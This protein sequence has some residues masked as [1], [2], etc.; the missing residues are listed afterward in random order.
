MVSIIVDSRESKSKIPNL[1]KSMNIDIIFKFLEVG[2][3]IIN[4]ETAVERKSV[5]DFVSSLFD[6]RLFNQIEQLSSSY[7]NAFLIIEGNYNEVESYM[8]NPKVVQCAIAS[9]LI[10]Y[11][12]KLINSY[13]EDETALFLS[14]L[15]NTT[16]SKRGEYFIKHAKKKDFLGQQIYLISSLPGIG[17]K[18]AVNL[19][20]HFGSPKNIFLASVKELSKVP[21]MGLKRAR[22]IRLLLDTNVKLYEQFFKN[23]A[24]NLFI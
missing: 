23:R 7:T 21:G 11:K 8:K 24:N 22:R 6:G 14:C 5:K 18:T 13:S 12:I 3:Y 15:L 19:L 9:L 1:L 20:K 2:D 17:Y 4:P 16:P 10:N